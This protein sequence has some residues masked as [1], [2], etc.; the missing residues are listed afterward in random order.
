MVASRQMVYFSHQAVDIW[1]ELWDLNLE[2]TV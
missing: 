1:Q 2:E